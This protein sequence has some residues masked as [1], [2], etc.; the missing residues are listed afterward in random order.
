MRVFRDLELAA[1]LGSGVP[2]ILRS[3]EKERFYG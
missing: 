2:G 3:Y 1:Q